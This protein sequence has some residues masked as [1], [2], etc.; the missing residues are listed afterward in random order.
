VIEG[1]KTLTA[2]AIEDD[3]KTALVD[4]KGLLRADVQQA[5]HA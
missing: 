5:R 2:K 3:L 4:W 1:T